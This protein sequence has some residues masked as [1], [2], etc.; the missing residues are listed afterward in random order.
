[1]SRIRED[2]EA[3]KTQLAWN[4]V[5]G[6]AREWWLRFETEQINRPE[7][8]L[9]VLEELK[10]RD[11]TIEEFFLAYVY[12]DVNNIQTNLDYLDIAIAR[13]TSKRPLLAEDFEN[14]RT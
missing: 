8:V 11:A 9:R 7:L 4:D 14:L 3:L 6:R 5:E 13:S 10:K 2:I 12:S 1:M